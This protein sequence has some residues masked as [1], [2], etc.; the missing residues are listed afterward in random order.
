MCIR[1]SSADLALRRWV[2]RAAEWSADTGVPIHLGEFGAFGGEGQVPM[3]D[4]A[5]WTSTVVDE[6]NKHGIP[7]SYWEFHAGYGAYDLDRGAWN[8]PLLDALLS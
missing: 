6:A 5:A 1:D 2:E 7:F 8:D 4:R 3:A